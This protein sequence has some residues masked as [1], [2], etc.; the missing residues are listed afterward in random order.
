MHND[1]GGNTPRKERESI[2]HHAPHI[3]SKHGVLQPKQQPLN[4]NG[5]HSAIVMRETGLQPTTI[6][7]FFN[8]RIGKKHNCAQYAYCCDDAAGQLRA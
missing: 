1:A 3:E 6:N 2:D 7:D 8:R 4:K 5:N